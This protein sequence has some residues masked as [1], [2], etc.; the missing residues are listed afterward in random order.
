MTIRS[1][2][3]KS[4]TAAPSLRNSGFDNTAKRT[5]APRCASVAEIT[6]RRR[7]AAPTG[8]VDFVTTTVG[9]VMLLPIMRPASSTW[10]K[11]AE[12]SSSEGVPTATKMMSPW[13]T[14]SAGSIVNRSRPESWLLPTMAASPGS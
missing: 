14:P 2:F 11:S 10:L 6:P 1:G 3:M 7:S 4:P 5:S 12:P 9:L 13:L 8:T